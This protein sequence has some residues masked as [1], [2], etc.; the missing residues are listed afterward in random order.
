MVGGTWPVQKSNMARVVGGSSSSSSVSSSSQ[1]SINKPF[2]CWGPQQPNTMSNPSDA[3]LFTTLDGCLHQTG[4]EG[5]YYL[6]S[7]GNSVGDSRWQ[8]CKGS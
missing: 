2:Q 5:L 6:G 1:A 7:Q 4:L 8:S 3:M